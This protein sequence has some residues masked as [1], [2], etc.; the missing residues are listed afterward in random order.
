SIQ[1]WKALSGVLGLMN[2]CGSPVSLGLREW[3]R[4]VLSWP[5]IF[6]L[7]SKLAARTASF[8]H[9]LPRRSFELNLTARRH[10]RARLAGVQSRTRPGPRRLKGDPTLSRRGLQSRK[11]RSTR[12]FMLEQARRTASSGSHQPRQ[13]VM[14]FLVIGL[15][16]KSLCLDRPIWAKGPFSWR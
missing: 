15:S 1:A 14:I 5:L 6:F 12:A 13:F 8:D 11:A 3:S 4:V 16:A 2:G 10:I 9:G 7:R